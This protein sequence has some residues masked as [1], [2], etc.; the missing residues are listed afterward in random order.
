MPLMSLYKYTIISNS[1]YSS[2][3]T[4]LNTNWDKIVIGPKIWFNSQ[5]CDEYVSDRTIC[6]D[7]ILL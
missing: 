4:F 1:V 5:S 3:S 6:K 7:W 2:W